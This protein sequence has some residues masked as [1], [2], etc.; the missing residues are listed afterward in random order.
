[1]L[2][3]G[4]K[5]RGFPGIVFRDGPAG[6]RAALA[7]GPDVWEIIRALQLTPGKGEKRVSRLADQAGLS[8]RQVRLAVDYY[9]VFSEEID[10]RITEDERAAERLRYRIQLR[11]S[12]VSG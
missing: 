2:D 4:L 3:E 5:T 6:R 12:L 10:E 1:M 9:S 7:D 8:S 11:D